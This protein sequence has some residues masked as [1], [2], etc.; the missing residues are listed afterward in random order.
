VAIAVVGDSV[1]EATLQLGLA[2]R[3]RAGGNIA[4]PKYS[5]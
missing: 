2:R 4:A 1:V 5:P 3:L